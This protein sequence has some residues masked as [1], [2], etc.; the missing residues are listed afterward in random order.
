VA[1]TKPGGVQLDALREA[2]QRAY[3]DPHPISITNIRDALRVVYQENNRNPDAVTALFNDLTQWTLFTPQMKPAEFFSQSWVIDVH[4]ATETAQRLVVF[5]MLDALYAYMKSLDDAP[6]DRQNHRRLRLVL[7]VDEARRV[8]N[9]G[10]LSLIGLV[11]ESRSKGA[12]VFLISQS[13]DD[14]DTAEEDFLSQIGLTACFR[15]NS[16]SS[17]VLKACLGQSVDLAGLAD[18][19]AVSRLPGQPG[20]ARI[21]VWE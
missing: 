6:M 16:T 19:V 11:R 5:L 8:L 7:V 4:E 3:M 13:P 18:G 20:V 1:K 10:Q 2:A 14:F 15:S 21:K 9:F 12:S 17:K